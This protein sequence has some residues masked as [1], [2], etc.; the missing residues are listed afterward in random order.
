MATATQKVRI[1]RHATRLANAVPQLFPGAAA[2]D[3][4]GEYRCTCGYRLRVFG[5]GRHHVYFEPG[6]SRLADPLI[7]HT[8][9]QCG[10]GL[11]GSNRS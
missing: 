10:R 7:A 3:G 1:A 11:P 6:S 8:C 2:D 5:L 4:R 9:P